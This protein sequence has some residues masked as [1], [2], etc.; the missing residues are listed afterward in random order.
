MQLFTVTVET[1]IVVLAESAE[2]AESEA[3]DVVKELEAY[4]FSAVAQ[5]LTRMPPGWS[6]K[7][8]PWGHQDGSAPDRT[9]K[10][11]VDLG[12]APDY[13][14]KQEKLE[15]ARLSKESPSMF[16]QR[17]SGVAP[18]VVAAIIH[19]DQARRA[20]AKQ[21]LGSATELRCLCGGILHQ[22][23]VYQLTEVIRRIAGP[24]PRHRKRRIQKKLIK[25]W[26]AKVRMAA[27]P[28]P[29]SPLSLRTLICGQCGGSQ[30]F[31]SAIARNVFPVEPMPPGAT[32]AYI[33]QDS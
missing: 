24:R 23:H 4:N 7:S 32:L 13:V 5:P 14:A 22:P 27:L 16:G 6:P 25:R 21:N 29:L 17:P 30:G 12:A 15:T 2:E 10:D 31:Y 3:C 19:Q 28:V 1:E 26:T 9:I 11:W 33:R 20:A 8:L 18:S